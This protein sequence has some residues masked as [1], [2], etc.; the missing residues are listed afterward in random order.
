MGPNSKSCRALTNDIIILLGIKNKGQVPNVGK[1]EEYLFS[2]NGTKI[3][4]LKM[5]NRDFEPQEVEPQPYF[6][7]KFLHMV[8]VHGH[9]GYWL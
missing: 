8:D 9:C 4:A 5:K 6:C 2:R 3:R 1:F 7:I